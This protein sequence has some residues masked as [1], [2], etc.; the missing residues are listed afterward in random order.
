MLREQG[1]TNRLRQLPFRTRLTLIL[2]VPFRVK[3]DEG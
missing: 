3:Y 1:H 2:R